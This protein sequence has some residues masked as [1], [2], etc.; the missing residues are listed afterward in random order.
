MEIKFGCF[1]KSIFWRWNF[2]G[3][4]FPINIELSKN[5]QRKAPPKIKLKIKA[6]YPKVES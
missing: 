1:L 3:S 2:S 5:F 4:L 6:Q